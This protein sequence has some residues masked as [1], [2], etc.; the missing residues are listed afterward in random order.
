VAALDPVATPVATPVAGPVTEPVIEPVVEPVVEPVAN[1][2]LERVADNV[3]PSIRAPWRLSRSAY[4]TAIVRLVVLLFAVSC[5]GTGVAHA[6]TTPGFDAVVLRVDEAP[7]ESAY[8]SALALI[9]AR[10]HSEALVALRRI[11]LTYPSFSKLSAVQTRVAVLHEAADA[12]DSLSVFLRAL[13]ARDAGELKQALDLLDW[14][15]RER[16][17]STLL[18]DALYLSAYLSVMDGYDFPDAQA[19]LAELSRRFPE[20]AYSDSADYLS[21]IVA[22]QMG[23]TA[24]A[25]STLVSLRDRHTALGLPFG[26]RWPTGNVLSR[27]WFD[28][29]DRRIDIIDRRLRTASRMASRTMLDDG[30]MRVG[31][32]V[33]GIDMQLLLSPSALVRDTDWKDARLSD[34]LPPD[35]GVYEGEVEGASN[36]WV[37][38]TISEGAIT[39]MIEISGERMRLLPGHLTGTLDYYQ[40]AS[41]HPAAG[42]AQGLDPTDPSIANQLQAIDLLRAPPRSD[43]AKITHRSSNRL[44]T[45]R[46]V[47][48]SI[49]VDSR[50]DAYHAGRGLATALDYLNIADGV[51]RRHGLAITLDEAIG[52]SDDADPLKLDPGPL[53]SFLRTFRDYRMAHETLFADSAAAYL[54]TG[55][56]KTDVTLGLAWIDTLCRTDGYDVGITT[57]SS[58]GDVL[59]THELGHSFGAQHDSDTSCSADRDGLMWPHIS[60]RTS[61][62]LTSCSAQSVATSRALSCLSNTVDL[63]LDATVRGDAV[64]F[65]ITNPEVTT[66][67]DARLVVETGVPGQVQWP[68]NCRVTTPTSADCLISTIGP[69]ERMEFQLPLNTSVAAY[70][71]PVGGKVEPIGIVELAPADNTATS[72]GSALASLTAGAAREPLSVATS[73]APSNDQPPALGSG[74]GA[75]SAGVWWLLL[76]PVELWRRLSNS[77]W[78]RRRIKSQAS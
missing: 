38:A 14:I 39:G 36:S 68:D 17:T 62:R 63:S 64:V 43:S 73:E 75:G 50:F 56:Q 37:R 44:T 41:R 74:S 66:G 16:T 49:V 5:V 6:A 7:A 57:P 13:N 52:F 4:A 55:N 51:Y 65:G 70:G 59:L 77:S 69:A 21:A 31:V 12:G 10:K 61:T 72:D 42:S 67:L 34:R 53:E 78:L 3:A 2:V 18:D 58:F 25:R 45:I 8:A 47:P 33:D 11:Q 26:F 54:F 30:R 48:L 1:A 20:S 40:P 9:D 22:E 15:A 19:R 24:T 29:A 60:D 27:Y 46:S 28:R 35:V 76:L 23:D 32:N 71:E